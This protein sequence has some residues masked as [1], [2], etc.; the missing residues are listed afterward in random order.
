MHTISYEFATA[1]AQRFSTDG[2]KI[3]ETQRS[4]F[5]TLSAYLVVFASF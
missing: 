1:D 5:H 2:K 4:F 3:L